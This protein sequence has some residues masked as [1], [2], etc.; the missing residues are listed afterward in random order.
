[1]NVKPA[2]SAAGLFLSGK[3]PLENQI[4]LSASFTTFNDFD[5]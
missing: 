2:A 3:L 1:M 5:F 4:I